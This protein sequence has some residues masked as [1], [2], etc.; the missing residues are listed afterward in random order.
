[1][2]T[3]LTKK[4][5]AGDVIKH[6]E[7]EEYCM[8][9]AVLKNVDAIVDMTNFDV[10]GRPVALAAGTATLIEGGDEAN[11]TGIVAEQG[12]ITLLAA[13]LSTTRLYRILARGPAVVW[14]S[15]MATLDPA[16]TAISPSDVGDALNAVLGGINARPGKGAL[17]SVQDT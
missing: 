1:M 7:S 8:E 6:F 5:I 4:T 15:G 17:T 16:G 14:E 12:H 13:T 11:T 10:G 2:A 3:T 9:E